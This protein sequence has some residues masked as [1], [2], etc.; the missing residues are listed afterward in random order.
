MWR[1]VQRW[2]GVVIIG[3][4]AAIVLWLAVTGQLALYIHPRYN[5]F[6]VTMSI[7]A[8]ILAV[9]S[10]VGRRDHDDEDAPPPRR[11]QRALGLTA[12]ALAGLFT[13]GMVFVP[14]ASLSTATAE[15][16]E[17]NATAGVDD[18]SLAAASEADEASIARFTVREWAG[19]L[20]Q[21]S[22]LSFFTDK[23]VTDLVGFTIAD[24]EDPD[25]VFYVSRFVVTC[26]AVDAQPLGV[27][28]HLPD[29]AAS[30]EPDSW[31]SVSGEFGSNPSSQS[32][33]PVVVIPDEVQT[34]E[35]PR[36]PYLF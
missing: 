15:Q 6:A 34:V 16:R 26:C 27:P 33:Q 9:A 4:M 21:T 30:F 7:I 18:E 35:Q 1:S 8:V 3:I 12:A 10:L 11:P 29:W 5:V 17:L 22:D 24:A 19:I 36:E 32:L 20:R 14:P 28:V 31:V 13:L 23:P 25:N 2:R